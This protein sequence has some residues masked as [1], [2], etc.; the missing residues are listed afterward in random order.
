MAE[1]KE[2]SK[3]GVRGQTVVPKEIR[4]ALQIEEGDVLVW[5]YDGEK[6]IVEVVK[7]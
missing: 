6:L 7:V 2:T 5:K 3:V 1:V 4:E